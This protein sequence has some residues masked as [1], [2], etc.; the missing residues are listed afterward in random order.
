MNPLRAFS[1]HLGYIWEKNR[2]RLVI[3][4]FVV[5][6]LVLLN[7]AR[8][9]VESTI[10]IIAAAPALRFSGVQAYWGHLQQVT[11]FSE[12]TRRVGEQIELFGGKKYAVVGVFAPPFAIIEK[13]F[14]SC[15]V[16]VPART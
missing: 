10:G 12:R 13:S 2:G 9:V 7:G 11:P 15:A 1:S 14:K 5:T 16:N 4:L 8:S 6:L 3:L